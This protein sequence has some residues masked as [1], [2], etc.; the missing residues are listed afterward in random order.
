[1]KRLLPSLSVLV[2]V[3]LWIFP[4]DGSCQARSQA[5]SAVT[6]E[7]LSTSIADLAQRVRPSVVQIRTVGFGTL[8]GQ[9][10]GWVAEQQGTGSGVILDRAGYI[11]TNAHVV[12]GARHIEVWLNEVSLQPG[13]AAAGPPERRSVAATLV[14]MDAEADLAVIKID[15]AGLVPMSLADSD[16]LR[17]GQFVLAFGNPMALEN[18]VSLGVV[19]SVER[20]LKPEDPAVYIQTDAPINPGNSGG[21]LVDARGQVVGINTFI[22]SKSG[23][24]EG[25]GFA[26]PSNAVSRIYDELRKTGHMHHGRIGIQ[27]LSVT[28]PLA[29]GLQLP[30][31][32]GVILEDVEPGGPADQAGLKPGDLVTA[33]DGANI[34]DMQQF[35]RTIDRHAIGEAVK[36]TVQ[37]GSDKVDADVTVAERADD[38]NRFLEMVSENA[39]LVPRLGILAID[40]NDKVLKMISELRKPAGVVVAARVAGLPGS[41][42]GLA[43]GDLIVSLNGKDVP[44]L[45]TLRGLLAD[46]Q[47]GSP[48]VLQI[49]REDQLRFIVLELP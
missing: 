18:S 39:N 34:R 4:A 30:R 35:F 32:W 31:D 17:Q 33:V 6:F 37:R 12:K 27:A 15:R 22:L 3:S 14:G 13:G 24:S 23:G 42:E 25:I 48:V 9:T 5:A 16:T 21:P 8:E 49:Q 1:M 38:P 20:Q 43:P 46:L 36:I 47:S 19:S 28:P 44:N 2:L 41:E 29:D 45:E 40:M 11:V 26:I 10:V 7:T